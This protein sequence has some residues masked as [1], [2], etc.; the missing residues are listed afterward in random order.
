LEDTQ[1]IGF[2]YAPI[3]LI[4]TRYRVIQHCNIQFCKMFGLRNE[5][6]EGQSL[7]KLYPSTEEFHR[8][9][10]AGL[11]RMKTSGQYV[12]ERIMRRESGDLFWCRVRGHALTPEDP[13]AQAIWSFADLSDNRPVLDISKRERQVAILVTKGQTSKEIAR[14]LSISPRTVEAHR[15]HL[16]EKFDARNSSELIARLTGMP[17]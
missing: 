13:F 4:I 17:L 1:N 8:I 2:I 9:G 16:L 15:A 3:G 5:Q 7:S 11:K 6:L 14:I 10:D 12:N